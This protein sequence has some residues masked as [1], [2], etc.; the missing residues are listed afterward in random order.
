MS[1]GP[2]CWTPTIEGLL[3]CSTAD[4][5]EGSTT[6]RGTA[7]PTRSCRTSEVTRAHRPAAVSSAHR[8]E[9]RRQQV[10]AAPRA[11]GAI[12]RHRRR[13]S[14]ELHSHSTWRG[15]TRGSPSS[16]STDHGDPAPRPTGRRCDEEWTARSAVSAGKYADIIA[17]AATSCAISRLPAR[18]HRRQARR[19]LQVASSSTALCR[20]RSAD[21][22]TVIGRPPLLRIG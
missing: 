11:G 17:A 15:W 2:L 19:P 4:N 22:R 3:N 13:H 20:F 14:D 6:R 10:Q 7:C 16:A 5:P 8:G 1:L 9:R 21:H 18:R 12:D